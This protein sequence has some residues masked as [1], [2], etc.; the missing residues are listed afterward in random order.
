MSVWDWLVL[1]SRRPQVRRAA[2]YFVAAFFA[3][4]GLLAIALTGWENGDGIA[5]IIVAIVCAVA[6]VLSTV[7]PEDPSDLPSLLEYSEVE[8]TAPAFIPKISNQ[9]GSIPS[10]ESVPAHRSHSHI[11]F[12]LAVGI[13]LLAQWMKD[14]H[15]F[16]A[17]Q[18][19][20]YGWLL[21]A[22]AAILAVWAVWNGGLTFPIRPES[23]E[24][25]VGKLPLMGNP[26]FIC[27]ASA[28][29]F[30]AFAFFTF[31][32]IFEP[33]PLLFLTFSLGYWLFGITGILQNQPVNILRSMVGYAQRLRK[34]IF[35]ISN[36]IAISPWTILWTVVFLGLCVLRTYHLDAVPPQM[37][38]DHVEKLMD[39]SGIGEGK[40]YI[41]FSNNGGRESLEFYLVAFVEAVFGTGVS[42]LSL[43]LVSVAD[44]LLALPFV[45]L[46]GK[47]IMGRRAGLLVMGLV[48]IGFWPDLISRIGLRFPLSPLFSAITI[49][50]FIRALRR[51]EW[52]S[53]IWA[54]LGLGVGL[55]GY[56]P[57]RILP[58]VMALGTVLF[59]VSPSSKGSRIWAVLGLCATC[60]TAG[61]LFIPML[62]F[63][64]LNP[65][66]FWLRTITRIAPTGGNIADPMGAFFV[67]FSQALRM[68]SENDGVGWFNLVPLRPALDIVTGAFFHLGVVAA[69]VFAIRRRSWE[70]AFLPLSIP[71]LLLPSILALALPSE[72]PSLT[73]ASAAIPIVFLIAA[74]AFLLFAE[75]L[76]HWVPTR[77]GSWLVGFAI[78]GLLAVAVAQNLFLTQVA[79]PTEYRQNCQNASEVGEYIKAF[80]KMG[81]G[82]EDVH[83]IPYPYWVD[84]RAVSIYADQPM[85]NFEVTAKDITKYQTTGGEELFLLFAKDEASLKALRE[86]FPQ[87]SWK[88]IIS[89]FP[90]KDFIVFQIPAKQGAHT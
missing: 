40:T 80:V 87:G 62:K 45:Y 67:N 56:T 60:F 71:I 1:E 10:A 36:G 31:S 88:V 90:G 63:A 76:R 61:I 26:Q 66:D 39:V 51:L 22:V 33:W 21:Y 7:P 74:F 4:W 41:F 42:F 29:G 53:F 9:A 16:G 11:I 89:A 8:A 18:S 6:G 77:A 48:G 35:L 83:T 17:D 50:F 69:I 25:S 3:G 68:F 13:A 59:L 57:I 64:F 73:R 24:P 32:N 58:L 14:V 81:N 49:Y 37:T 82:L 46:I 15:P 54:G 85:H 5:L 28:V 12:P 78:A 23:I 44:G 52:N 79:Y 86:Q 84:G 43:R 34:R 47:E 70:S 38:S 30:A 55:Y 19:Q 75:S 72:N 20:P 65:N 27:F 2:I